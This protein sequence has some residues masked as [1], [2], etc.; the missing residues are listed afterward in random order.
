MQFSIQTADLATPLSYVSKVVNSNN[1]S[2]PMLAN[3]LFKVEGDT[4]TITGRDQENVVT[5][6]VKVTDVE[7]E[8]CIAVPAKRV[9]DFPDVMAGMTLSF[10]ID[11][12]SKQITV[13]HEG[14]LFSMMGA[15]AADFPAVSPEGDGET[16]PL[17]LS[18]KTLREAI[19]NTLYAVSTDTIR[20]AMTGTFWDIC[21]TLLDGQR[22]PGIVFVASDTHKL[23]RFSVSHADPGF[24]RSFIM[25]A[26]PSGILRALIAKLEDNVEITADIHEKGAIFTVGANTL[27][28]RFINGRFPSYD[29]VIPLQNPFKLEVKRA[30]F[31][32]AIKRMS[33]SASLGT[34]LVSLSLRAG[35]MLLS[36]KDPDLN[37]SAAER[38]GCTYSGNDMTI[39]F[40]S[41]YLI[42]VLSALPADDVVLSLADPARPG[43]FTPKTQ[44]EGQ[45]L[46]VLL[47]PMQ[48]IE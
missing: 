37:R 13:G 23:V 15:D 36:A 7:G 3:L 10:N 44:L 26:K 45:K 16:Q 33:L 42:E 46:L 29:R 22:F 40:N 24:T 32:S 12:D 8:G 41:D 5:A 2:M 48:I 35:E 9:L 31:L 38:I 19:D 1:T 17:K 47:M 43:V 4:L 20:P 6:A 28:C 21:P 30:E 25:A 27:T 11:T 14:G 39:G 34:N 18:A